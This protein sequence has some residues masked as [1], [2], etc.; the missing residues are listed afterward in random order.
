MKQCEYDL[1]K[2]CTISGDKCSSKDVKKCM[3]SKDYKPTPWIDY[4]EIL[5]VFEGK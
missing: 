4:N 3:W 1:G 2:R 5:D